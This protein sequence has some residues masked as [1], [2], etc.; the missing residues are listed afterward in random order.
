MTDEVRDFFEKQQI[1]DQYDSLKAM[2]RDLD[3]AAASMLNSAMK[4]DILSIGGIWDHY[5][6]NTATKSLTVV[7]LSPLMLN[8]YCPEGAKGIVGDFFE[9]SLDKNSYDI[10][11]FPLMLHHTPKGTWRQSQNRVTEALELAS[12]LIRPGGELFIL[13]YCPQKFW[14]PFQ[15][16][17]YPVTRIFLKIF[18]QPLVAMYPERFYEHEIIRQFGNCKIKRI[19]TDDQNDRRWYPVFMSIRWLKI[20]FRWY[21]KLTLI[22]STSRIS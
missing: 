10:L 13:E 14:M 8:A 19:S 11:V 18:S 2:T 22:S 15:K 7:D 16:I 3:L 20:P 21:P 1:N 17:L 12:E 6:S 9:L 5:E 4:G